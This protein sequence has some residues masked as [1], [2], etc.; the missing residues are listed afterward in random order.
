M[1]PTGDLAKFIIPSAIGL[2][3][4]SLVTF[5]GGAPAWAQV[6][7]GVAMFAFI[8]G[9][10]GFLILGQSG[11]RELARRYPDAAPPP[12]PGRPARRR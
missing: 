1:K 12:A 9:L 4:V 3:L 7:V 5:K 8:A 10:V 2:W 6:A 11:W